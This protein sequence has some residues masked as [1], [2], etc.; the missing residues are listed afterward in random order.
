DRRLKHRAERREQ[1]LP[2]AQ[3]E[4][5]APDIV[6]VHRV[7]IGE[8]LVLPRPHRASESFVL[9]QDVVLEIE[10]EAP[11][12]E[13]GASNQAGAAVD[14]H[15]LRMEQAGFELVDFDAGVDQILVVAA[16]RGGYD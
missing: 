3:T 11:A 9:E 8:I 1:V 12:V 16:A 15:R 5:V 7:A 6:A 14:D 2:E 4:A 13:V 10:L